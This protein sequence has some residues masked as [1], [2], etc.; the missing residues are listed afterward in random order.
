MRTEK[1]FLYVCAS[2]FYVNIVL[3][4]SI[5][6]TLTDRFSVHFSICYNQ[7]NNLRKHMTMKSSF[8][9]NNT[10]RS[11]SLVKKGRLFVLRLITTNCHAVTN[12]HTAHREK[13][14]SGWWKKKIRWERESSLTIC[15]QNTKRAVGRSR[16][17]EKIYN[18]CVFFEKNTSEQD[19]EKRFFFYLPI[20]STTQTC[21]IY[22]SMWHFI[23]SPS[24]ERQ[25]RIRWC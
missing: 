15:F 1:L 12:Q 7:T 10:L 22:W 16:R 4:L 25:V 11:S 9:D 21:S 18:D 20:L 6:Y 17:K 8:I 13:K 5:D 24:L 14:R 23:H 2:Y 19:D 3:Y